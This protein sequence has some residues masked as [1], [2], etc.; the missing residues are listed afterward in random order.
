MKKLFAIF[1]VVAAI[2]AVSCSSAPATP[3]EAAV[4]VYELMAAGE[5]EAVAEEFHFNIEDPEDLAEAKTMI[6]SLA[7]EKGGPQIEAKGGL[8]S[9]EVL[10]EV[11]AEDGQTAKVTLKLVYGNGKE[12]T[13]K[14]DLVKDPEGDW[15]AAFNK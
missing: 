5:Y 8:V 6:V 10:E 14:V 2:F 11:V 15:K 13:Q 9:T 4:K 12:E 7:E 3:G 1:A